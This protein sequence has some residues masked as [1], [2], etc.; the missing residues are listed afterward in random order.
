D[1]ASAIEYIKSFEFFPALSTESVDVDELERAC[2]NQ[3]HICIFLFNQ[4]IQEKCAL[5]LL[6]HRFGHRLLLVILGK[7]TTSCP[8]LDD[9]IMP[10]N[11][12][13]KNNT[14]QTA[15]VTPLVCVICGNLAA[16]VRSCDGCRSFFRRMI[17]GGLRND[18]C[19]QKPTA[20]GA[21]SVCVCWRAC[22]LG[23]FEKFATFVFRFRAWLS[24]YEPNSEQRLTLASVLSTATVHN[25]ANH[26]NHVNHVNH[27]NHANHAIQIE[28]SARR[29]KDRPGADLSCAVEYIKTFEFFSSLARVS[30]RAIILRSALVLTN[31]TSSF[32]SYIKSSNRDDPNLSNSREIQAMNRI[33]LCDQEAAIVKALIVSNPAIEGI[34]PADLPILKAESGAYGTMLFRVMQERRGARA[35]VVYIE[36]MALIEGLLH[37]AQKQKNQHLLLS[38]LGQAGIDCPLLDEVMSS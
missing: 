27:A 13:A 19:R 32:S 15:Q 10:S 17:H 14:D 3:L 5:F 9:V 18:A 28:S 1:L 34:A 31:F 37:Q 24:K 23:T 20:N 38:L 21:D 26:T 29:K 35:P 2:P 30:K 36:V 22:G 11:I 33:A 7:E 25:H 8:L 4:R 6:L 12:M 16:G